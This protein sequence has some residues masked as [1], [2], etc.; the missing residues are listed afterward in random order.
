MTYEYSGGQ[1]VMLKP[2]SKEIEIVFQLTR[3][4]L[5]KFISASH[6][7]DGKIHVFKVDCLRIFVN[8]KNSLVISS[9]N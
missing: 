2:D 6:V 8:G 3:E 4:E 9:K 5:V 7:K 1:V